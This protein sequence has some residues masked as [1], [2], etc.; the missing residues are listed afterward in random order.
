M[1]LITIESVRLVSP[2]LVVRGWRSGVTSYTNV[3]LHYSRRGL[4]LR[5]RL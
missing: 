2:Y 1:G 3:D 4:S 5:L